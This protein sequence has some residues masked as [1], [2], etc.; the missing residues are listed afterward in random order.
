M[1]SSIINCDRCKNICRQNSRKLCQNCM[2]TVEEQFT[3]LY[4]VLQSSG[5]HGGI[6][7]SDLS[8]QVGA[9][10]ED[11]ER[12]YAEGRFS[13]ASAYLKLPCQHCKT[14]L[15]PTERV[16]CTECNKTVATKAGVEIKS[17]QAL[18]KE[19]ED[20]K[21]LEAQQALLKKKTASDLSRSGFGDFARHSN[22]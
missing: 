10:M 14:I 13:T 19:S 22:R 8:V 7:L 2:A 11:I 5:A 18:K 9:S 21:R 6:T 17:L 1:E 4:R 15:G 3:Q 12:Y 16:Y 20:E